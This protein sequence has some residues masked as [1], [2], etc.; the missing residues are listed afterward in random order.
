[1]TSDQLRRFLSEAISSESDLTEFIECAKRKI[2]PADE[3]LV[4]GTAL[5]CREELW[6]SPVIQRMIQNSAFENFYVGL[7]CKL[8]G[9]NIITSELS[10]GLNT[11]FKRSGVNLSKTD[12][13]IRLITLLHR[14]KIID[15]KQLLLPRLGWFSQVELW[16]TAIVTFR[17]CEPSLLLDTKLMSIP[18]VRSARCRVLLNILSADMAGEASISTALL[19]KGVSMLHRLKSE[20]HTS[21]VIRISWASMFEGPKLAC[22]IIRE[23]ARIG[24][25]RDCE[26]LVPF[27]AKSRESGDLETLTALV[28]SPNDKAAKC[29]KVVLENPND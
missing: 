24:D 22:T 18:R 3:N 10:R 7:V 23:M 26:F 17:I 25:Y 21:V 27:L 9:S 11:L 29:A 13:L 28:A 15:A 16:E 14:R 4:I 2:E 19:R 1:M 5:C 6:R 8:L 20:D 12:S